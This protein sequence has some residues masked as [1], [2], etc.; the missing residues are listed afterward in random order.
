[1]S[2]SETDPPVKPQGFVVSPWIV[3]LLVSIALNVGGFAYTWGTVVTRLDA[4]SL[5][6]Q[7]LERLSDAERER[8]RGPAYAVEPP[9]TPAR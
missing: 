7:R 6:V 8:T 2:K 1:M 3:T 5:Q 9:V 4:L